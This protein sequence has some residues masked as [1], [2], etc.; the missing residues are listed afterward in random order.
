[1]QI[2]FCLGE[3]LLQGLFLRLCVRVGL[4]LRNFKF[5]ILL[6]GFLI[7]V[8]GFRHFLLMFLF[9][10]LFVVQVFFVVIDALI[11]CL[12]VEAAPK[13]DGETS[14]AS[15]LGN[16]EVEHFLV[17]CHVWHIQVSFLRLFYC[18]FFPSLAF[19]LFRLWLRL[20]ETLVGNPAIVGE[21]FHQH[22]LLVRGR[23][24]DI[25]DELWAFSVQLCSRFEII[26][27]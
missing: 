8:P 15:Q 24:P 16:F 2:L 20:L 3:L 27:F 21:H 5:L 17:L 19:R 23:S 4:V 6:F 1:M 26:R 13:F 11:E 7:F 9:N 10:F 12:R 25:L 22:D 18:I 14:I